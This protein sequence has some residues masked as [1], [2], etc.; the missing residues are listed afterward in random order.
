VQVAQEAAGVAA[1]LTVFQ[2]TPAT[3]LFPRAD[4]WY[5]G[6]NIPGKRREMLIFA[7]GLPAY[8]AKCN[9]N[10][11]RGYEGFAIS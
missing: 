1:H 11:E 7:G 6:A 8:I 5:L 4:S 2:R 10:A 3:T 9:E